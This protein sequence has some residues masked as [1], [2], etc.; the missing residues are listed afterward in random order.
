MWCYLEAWF[1]GYSGRARH[2]AVASAGRVRATAA[3]WLFRLLAREGERGVRGDTGSSS[4]SESIVASNLHR[5]SFGHGTSD[6]LCLPFPERKAALLLCH[7]LHL[8]CC[9]G[10][11][12]LRRPR[13]RVC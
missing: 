13:P 7:S 1:V 3:I 5:F 11:G 9:K 8:N 2:T 4:S 12:R 6:R 10:A